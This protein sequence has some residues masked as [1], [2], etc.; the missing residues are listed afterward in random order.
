MPIIYIDKPKGI[1]S[2]KLCDMLK[3][4]LHTKKIG[5]TGTLDPN[6]T[7]LMVIL[8]DEACKANQFLVNDTKE[9]EGVC[10]I[11]ILTDTQDI[12][13]NIIRKENTKMPDRKSIEDVMNSFIGKYEQTPPMTSAIKVN[14]KKLY[15]YFRNN[16]EVE[17]KKRNVEIFDLKLLEIKDDEFSFRCKVSSGTYVRTLLQDILAKLNIFG[18]LIELRRIKVDDISIDLANTIEDVKSNKFTKYSMY[19][20]LSER[21]KTYITDDPKCIKDGKRLKLSSYPD[22]IFVVDSDLNPLAI[23]EKQ[24]DE[25]VSKR[26]LF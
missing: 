9:Y 10:K 23:Y 4:I 18:T 5:H 2:F 24:N 20:V 1:T 19:E 22:T 11:G 8:Y 15:E 17:V 7:G 25:Y 13:G 21:Y 16:E 14:G 12:D 26:G 6:A 3:G